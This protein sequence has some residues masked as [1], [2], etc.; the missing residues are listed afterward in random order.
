M[1]RTAIVELKSKE[2]VSF[3]VVNLVD[4]VL[5]KKRSP[6]IEEH[7]IDNLTMTHAGRMEEVQL[8]RRKTKK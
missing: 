3:L 5:D 8:Q 1:L 4:C 6:L 2:L 7:F